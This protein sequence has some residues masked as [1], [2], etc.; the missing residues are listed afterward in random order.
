MEF[1]NQQFAKAINNWACYVSVYKNNGA[2][3]YL[4]TYLSI[5]LFIHY[6]LFVS[7]TYFTLSWCLCPTHKFGNKYDIMKIQNG[8]N[9]IRKRVAK[10]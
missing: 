1:V 10:E 7:C 2:L 9:Y 6:I 8:I 4:F 3:I 5:S